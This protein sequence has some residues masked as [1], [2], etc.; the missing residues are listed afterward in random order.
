[1]SDNRKKI[2]SR[3]I[4]ETIRERKSV[5]TYNG[6]PLPSTVKEKMMACF[7]EISGNFGVKVRFTL[8]DTAR[9]LEHCGVKFGTYGVITGAASYIVAAVTRNDKDMEAV[10]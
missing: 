2:F 9:F 7:H 1:M 10:G 5:R 8:L 3:P 6:R 4:T